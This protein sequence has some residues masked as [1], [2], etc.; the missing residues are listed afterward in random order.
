[1][2][3]MPAAL[4]PLDLVAV[5]LLLVAWLGTGW[6]C[7]HPPASRPSV[8]LLMKHYRRAWMREMVE[9]SPRIFDASVIDSLRRGTAFFASGSMIAVGGGMALIGDPDRLATLVRDLTLPADTVRLELRVI[10]VM[11]IVANAFLKFVWS[12]RVFGYCAILMA[13][14]PN[15]ASDPR[16]QPLAAQAAEININ[17]ARNFNSGLRA[18]FFALAALGWLLGP[19]ALIATTLA[20]SFVI[21]RAEFA[22]GTRAAILDQTRQD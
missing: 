19:L 21:L 14:V 22:S 15:E 8:S 17:A 11:F 10:L 2:I 5:T 1:M 4:A 3:S 12:H 6:L 13:A 20:T 7:E 18:V 16:A 9:R